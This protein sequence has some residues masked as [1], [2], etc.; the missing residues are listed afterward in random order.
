M[1]QKTKFQ[2]VIICGSLALAV[3]SAQAQ[4]LTYSTTAPTVGPNGIANQTGAAYDANNVGGNGSNSSSTISGGGNGGVNDASTYVAFDRQLAQGQ[5]FLSGNNALGYRLNS[6]SVQMVGYTANNVLETTTNASPFDGTFWNQLSGTTITASVGTIGGGTFG[7]IASASFAGGGAGNPG[8]STSPNGAGTWLTFTFASPVFLAAN[9]AY[10]FDLSATNG[11][12]FEWLG[13][14]D[15][16]VGGG[17]NP[18]ASGNAFNTGANGAANTT[19]MN[20]L[21]GDRVFALGITVPEPSTFALCG[22]GGL[23][24]L[25]RRR[26]KN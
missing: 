22:L 17:G 3:V 26:A 15:T 10:G 20:P 19:T 14:S 2:T 4:T 12:Y 6:I 9:T 1:N 18:Y 24:F 16:A 23:A 7:S 11:G 21:A 25:F 5:T 13:I 8:Q